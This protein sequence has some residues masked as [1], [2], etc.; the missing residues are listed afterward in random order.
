MGI[1]PS[2]APRP[3][4]LRSPDFASGQL[5]LRVFS[6][7]ERA[8]VEAIWL[9][10]ERLHGDGGLANSWVWTST[11]L[12]HYGDVVP[13]RF[14]VAYA[15]REPVGVALITRG[16]HIKRGPLHLRTAHVGTAGEPMGETVRVQYNR[17]LVNP[18]HR[19]EFAS[20]ILRHAPAL[21]GGTT[22]L[23]VLEGFC[24]GEF[25]A[26]EACGHELRMTRKTAFALDLADVRRDGLT[27]MDVLR[28]RTTSNIR[29]SVK[30]LTEQYGPLSVEWAESLDHAR[31]IYDEM[32]VLHNARWRAEGQPG[33]FESRR[34]DGFHRDIVSRLIADQ[35]IVLARVKAG[36]KTVGCDYDFIERGR[37]LAYQWGLAQLEDSAISAGLVVG[38]LVMQAALERGL[39]EYDWLAG[40]VLYKRMLSTAEHQLV[41]AS[42]P[43][44]PVVPIVDTV[45]KL[46]RTFGS[47]VGRM[48]ADQ[49]Q[50]A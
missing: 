41:W 36:D 4:P 44:G 7:R 14:V 42:R 9:E 37:V 39:D 50:A 12:D 48:R 13:H 19:S 5:T 26:F 34:F 38:A 17:L 11:W 27:V 22:H 10:V 21:L 46:T 18:N 24:P 31:E 23:M 29:R 6:Q 32:C 33:V 45:T 30:R 49:A 1:L 3:R 25:S 20:L 16:H 40:D 47:T 43:I 15:G 8:D 2:V 28:K 35:R